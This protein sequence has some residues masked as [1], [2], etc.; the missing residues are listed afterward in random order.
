MNQFE[1]D[2]RQVADAIVAAN[3]RAA[4]SKGDPLRQF[5]SAA[6]LLT[7][8]GGDVAQWAHW[9][10]SEF[11]VGHA[12]AVAK[13][14]L[15]TGAV[16]AWGSNSGQ[17]LARAFV[18]AIASRSLWD[19]VALHALSVPAHVSHVYAA[20]YTGAGAVGE[21]AAKPVGSL[22]L[23]L[24]EADVVKVAGLA[25]FSDELVSRHYDRDARR[26]I[27]RELTRVVLDSGNA[28]FLDAI[29]TTTE[30]VP[31]GSSVLTQIHAGIAAAQ[32]SVG[33]VVSLTPAQTLALAAALPDGR[34]GPL[35]GSLY[36]GVSIVPVAGASGVT[37]V[38]SSAFVLSDLGLRLD[39]SRE[40][41]LELT[42]T[43]TQDSGT[44]TAA[45]E[46]VSL[47]Q[48]NSVAL[49]AERS[50]RMRQTADAVSVEEAE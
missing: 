35:G 36:E 48:T 33:Y 13:A 47:Y 7:K 18:D 28:A 5:L 44:P 22:E 16:E 40:A 9:L 29:T 10:D 50:W 45:T 27:E 14:A 31:V 39:S 25:V 1:F 46:H 4:N 17:V 11:G 42:D 32:T 24:S 30:T 3:E 26:A 37:V 41:T 34:I 20:T 21:G 15:T 49:L 43:P 23:N 8:S 6:I 2:A 12:A 19:Q 38:P